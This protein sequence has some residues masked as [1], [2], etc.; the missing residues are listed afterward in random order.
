MHLIHHDVL[1]TL[2]QH[3]PTPILHFYYNGDSSL[4]LFL[5]LSDNSMENC[6]PLARYI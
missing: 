5:S 6:S 1:R 2:Y 3:N 4:T